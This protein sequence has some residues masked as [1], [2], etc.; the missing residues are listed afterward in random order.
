MHTCR[1]DSVHAAK[2]VLCCAAQ[3]PRFEADGHEDNWC[4]Q[5]LAAALQLFMLTVA[6]LAFRQAQLQTN[7]T[8]PGTLLHEP[9][10]MTS[11]P[12][13][14]NPEPVFGTLKPDTETLKPDAGNHSHDAGI[15]KP[16]AAKSPAR[17][18]QYSDEQLQ[19]E[20][21]DLLSLLGERLVSCKLV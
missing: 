20:T 4:T 17:P 18:V 6:H 15:S 3:Y 12:D 13:A 14:G 5:V 10:T 9:D 16:D 8:V 7:V 19:A 11:E 1:P 21:S 2:P